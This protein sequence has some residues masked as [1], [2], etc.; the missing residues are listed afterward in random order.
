[1]KIVA[2]LL[3]LLDTILSVA[4]FQ[5]VETT[6]LSFVIVMV[7]V[8]SFTML[9][10]FLF[11]GN[12]LGGIQTTRKQIII[13]DYL[14]KVTTF[15]MVTMILVDKTNLIAVLSDMN[16]G[17]K[18]IIFLFVITSIALH[19]YLV[20]SLYTFKK[21]KPGVQE[22]SINVGEESGLGLPHLKEERMPLPQND[23]GCMQSNTANHLY[24]DK[25][26][27]I[28]NV[29]YPIHFQINNPNE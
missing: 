16:V 1:M 17:N 5:F 18:I 10:L 21:I 9:V 19:H 24:F 7:Y 6:F 14:I 22:H 26:Y 27:S 29:E 15:G 13:Y 23:E 3:S 8:V 25:E 11:F 12:Y 20:G 28:N 2:V 4:I